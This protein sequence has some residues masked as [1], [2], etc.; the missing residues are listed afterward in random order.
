MFARF[1]SLIEERRARMGV[2]PAGAARAMPRQ[3]QINQLRLYSTPSATRA[4]QSLKLLR[5]CIARARRE[6]RPM[7]RRG[8]HLACGR[9]RH[10]VASY[11]LAVLYPRTTLKD[12][13]S[14]HADIPFAALPSR[15]L[16]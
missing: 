3:N 14:V 9:S 16:Q 10:A 2:G 6:T 11:R 8:T 5:H 13:S 12:V 7:A 1:P 15:T 4:E